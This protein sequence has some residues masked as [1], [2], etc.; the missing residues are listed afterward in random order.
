MRAF[1]LPV[2]VLAVAPLS[3]GKPPVAASKASTK[4][5]ETIAK[6][7][8]PSVVKVLQ[9]GREGLDGLGTGFVVSPDG[10]IATNLHVIGEARRLEV[11]LSDGTKHDVTEITATDSHW[12]LALLRITA[13]D[14][15]PL[16]LGD[17]DSIKQGQPVVAMGNPEGLAFSIVDGVVSEY[18][19][20]VRDVPMIR[21]AM[22]IE[23]GN[24]G[25]PLL[26]R[27]G[28]VLGLITMKH[29]I[30]DNLGYA[31]PVNEL[32]HLIAKPN[33][34]PIDRWI[35]IGVLNSKVWQPALGS[36]WTQRSGTIKSAGMGHGFGGR[37]LCL[38]NA[39][40]PQE[41]FE[42]SVNVKLDDESGA[43]GLLFCAEDEDHYY[44]FYPSAGKMRF[45]RFEGPDVYSWVVLKEFDTEAYRPG[46]WNHLRIRVEPDQIIGW[47]NGQ[48]VLVHEDKG[49]RG[50]QVG[51]CRFR[52]PAAEYRGFRVGADLGEKAIPETVA[53][54]IDTALDQFSSSETTRDKTLDEL[55]QDPASARRLLVERRR[56]LEKQ[57][58]ALR[59]LEKDLHRRAVTRD[60]MT[61]LAKPEEKIDLMRLTLLLA[62]HD[63]TE[64]DVAQYLQQFT[65][66]VDELKTDPEI[67][68]GTASAVPRLSRFLFEECGFHGSRHDYDSKA[69]SSMSELLDDR[70]GLPIT[71][72]VL[73]IELARRLEVP[74]VFG[75]PLPG[76]FMVGWKDGP[77]GEVQLVDAFNRGKAMTVTE[78]ALELSSTGQFE[79]PELQPASKRD[80]ILRILRNLL[81][82]A[83]DSEDTLKDSLP[84]LDLTVAIDPEAS[85][86]RITRAQ[87]R[88]RLGQKA[89]A[90]EDVQW[91]IEH[92]PESA[93]EE[94]RAKLDEWMQNLRD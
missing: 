47:V 28:N 53:S 65:R 50:G 60:I 49:L 63:N 70:E 35:T 69:N 68:K 33:P 8:K 13:K 89:A 67:K 5:V 80:T 22:P 3:P 19:D 76:R 77:E 24:S 21:L 81:G 14:L 72:S 83:L 58:A 94:L 41:T 12:D 79:E 78:A 1:L 48:R 26:D 30:T 31:M 9:D 43:A 11:E 16:P 51:L 44:G 86:E 92:F 4:T 39:E 61:E 52:S 56:E 29:S 75:V 40:V 74:D 36:R 6:E 7:V 64:I 73:F 10:L 55:L 38:S 45:T 25:G 20:V 82:A 84:Y 62:R 17:S 42:V 54:A 46:A 71:L 85:M 57:T 90:R 18:P 87:M 91:L 23:R 2:L 27:Q 37:T 66:M 59:D 32:K 34:V 93:P 88:Q 15:K